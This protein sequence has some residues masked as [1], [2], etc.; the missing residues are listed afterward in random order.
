VT[1]PTTTDNPA[2]VTGP[3]Q[4]PNLPE[5]ASLVLVALGLLGVRRS[6]IRMR[7]PH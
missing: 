1:V 7:R 3:Q 5:P 6:V 4:N 2:K